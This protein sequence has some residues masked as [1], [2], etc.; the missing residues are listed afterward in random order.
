ML[1]GPVFGTGQLLFIAREYAKQRNNRRNGPNCCQRDPFTLALGIAFFANEHCS[2]SCIED[3]ERQRY[4]LAVGHINNRK[5]AF[6]ESVISTD[7]L[8]AY[9]FQRSRLFHHDL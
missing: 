9:L 4:S 2:L 6:W 5:Y 7:R 1:H 3:I 8:C